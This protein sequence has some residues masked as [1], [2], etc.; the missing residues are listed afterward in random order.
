MAV[1][2]SDP[3]TSHESPSGVLSSPVVQ[4][5]ELGIRLRQRREEIGLT[6][7]A[8]GRA[9]GI[10]QAY[11]TGVETG[12]V[13][14]PAKRLEQ[15]IKIYELEP[16]DAAELE[17]LRAGA[18]QRGWWHEYSQLFPAE[19]IR[20]L[21]YEAGASSVRTYQSDVIDGL[22]QTEDYARAVIRGGTTTIRLTE[23]ERRV[24]A[25]MARQ[26][27][28]TGERPIQI[29]AVLGEGVLRQQVGGP[30]VMR[31]QLDHL[32]RLMTERPEQVEI[33]VMPFSVGAHPALGGAFQI[34]SF[35][36]PQ[37]PDLVWQEILTSIDII[38]QSVRVTDYV[39]TFAETR[40]LTLS[41]EDSLA[42]IRRI[43]KEMT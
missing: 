23:V 14:L 1:R 7:T 11:V 20:F 37:L 16:E 39:V 42:L 33:R 35:A 5:W 18:T 2:A 25:R 34:L 6:A 8:A 41:S 30:T 13:K 27:R 12:K 22:L 4:G 19:F 3:S 36:P 10:I 28:L 40:E 29:S 24:A 17:A 32:A 15:L 38:D 43:A 9:A 21:G 31:G 26:A